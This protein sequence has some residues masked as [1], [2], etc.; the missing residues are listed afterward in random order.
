[1]RTSR[2]SRGT[3]AGAPP[4][5]RDP[6]PRPASSPGN[7]NPCPR[8][9][10]WWSACRRTRRER[11]GR[12]KRSRT[13]GRLPSHHREQG[14]LDPEASVVPQVF[15]TPAAMSCSVL[16]CLRTVDRCAPKNRAL[17]QIARNRAGPPGP[18]FTG[19]S[20]CSGS[21][22]YPRRESRGFQREGAESQHPTMGK[23]RIFTPT[24]ARVICG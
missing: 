17:D 12:A 1:M 13:G 3:R 2:G 14:I 22:G 7:G 4:S 24:K 11:G 10:A 20:E 6:R 23:S 18:A 15:G 16:P 21:T 9:G 8:K 19:D 5:R